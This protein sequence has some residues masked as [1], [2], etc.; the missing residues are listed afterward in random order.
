MKKST[1]ITSLL[2][3]LITA[4]ISTTIFADADNCNSFYPKV[5]YSCELVRVKSLPLE[6]ADFSAFETGTNTTKA[7]GSDV[8]Y[9]LRSV[10]RDTAKKL[11]SQKTEIMN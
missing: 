8:Q 7:S 10:S 11:R 3:A 1:Q 6:R 5:P 4:S 9:T 2:V